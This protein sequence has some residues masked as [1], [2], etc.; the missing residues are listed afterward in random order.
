MTRRHTLSAIGSIV[1]CWLATGL[2]SALNNTTVTKAPYYQGEDTD[3][4]IDGWL[5]GLVDATL[6]DVLTLLGR[7]GNFLIGSGFT[8]QGGVGSAGVLLTGALVGGV[9]FGSG[10]RASV[11]PVGGLV[12]ATLAAFG[13]VA[14]GIG[15]SWLYA[16]VLFAIG[17]IAT[18][19]V[20]RSLK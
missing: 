17:V 8:A 1:M 15:P 13:F 11:G 10:A 7:I 16:T 3:V 14:V 6:D 20:I 18:G 19:A 5:S 2:A 9:I 4:G 12:F